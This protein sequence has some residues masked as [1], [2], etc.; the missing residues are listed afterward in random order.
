[1]TRSWRSAIC[2]AVFGALTAC[3]SLVLAQ[4]PQTLHYQGYLTSS[5]GQPV[6]GAAQITFR[7]Y[8]A[9]SGGNLLWQETHASVNVAD[10]N[11]QAILGSTTPFSLPFDAQYWLGITVGADAEM[12][13]R[14]ALASSGY[15]LRSVIADTVPAQSVSGEMIAPGAITLEKLAPVCNL[16]ETLRR[17]ESGWACAPL[18]TPAAEICDGKDNNCDGVVDESWLNA[19]QYD[20]DDA[21][22][23]CG[24]DCTSIYAKPNATG[25]CD[26]AGAPVCVM[27]CGAGYFDL[28]ASVPDGCEFFLE[29]AAIY[30]SSAD[31]AGLDDES[32]GLGPVGTGGGHYPCETI[33]Q[34]L[35]RAATTARTKVLVADGL[36][37][38][39]VTLANGRS[40]LGGYRADTWE[41]HLATTS[42]VIQGVSSTGNH[43]RTVIAAGIAS[44][45]VFEGFVVRGALNNKLSGNSYAIYVS[46]SNA[47][48]EIRNNVIQAGRGGPGAAGGAGLGGSA[49]GSGGNGP[50][51]R[52]ATGTG[53]CDPINDRPGG[54]GGTNSCGVSANGG[55]GGGNQ[56]GPSGSLLEASGIDG[57]SGAGIGAGAGGDAGDDS[58]L[59]SNGVQ[60]VVPPL[61][62]IG[63]GGIAGQ[64]GAHA[65]AA[66][67]CGNAI[68]TVTGGHWVASAPQAGSSGASG[69]GGG[70]GGGGGG[71]HCTSCSELKDRLGGAGGGGGA[72]GCG[73]AGG[74]AGGNA[75]GA[76]GV[77]VA[78][79]GAPVVAGNS[80]ARGDGGAGGVGGTGGAGGQGGAGGA[81]GASV[82]CTGPGGAGGV[83]GAGGHGSGG[84]GGC[85][86]SSFGIYT[87]GVGAPDYCQP[88]AGNTFSAGST[89]AGGQGGVSLINPG[90]AGLA[91]QLADCSFH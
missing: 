5:A 38:E 43:D 67:G 91:G 52:I 45:T 83:G 44:P 50:I 9:A 34:G 17:T 12:A 33:A 2:A 48:L 42:T 63:A 64:A 73:G 11:Y 49:G 61:P 41:R 79:G 26:A 87:S 58:R 51:A 23:G 4:V 7:L 28:N 21:C 15:A 53:F 75:G 78:S 47:S 14:Q 13:P 20:R 76:F 30:V 60:C 3:A 31:P 59:E 62:V 8:D 40:L 36:Y 82:F 24:I 10:G 16:G 68:G 37:G 18:C 74:A 81:G 55:G 29:P 27:N 84:G 57:V 65:G 71:A 69:A 35:V 90:G 22:G 77:F 80:V 66:S 86:G 6:S 88:E 70:G 54:A 19:G 85:G 72:G 32:C 1:V 56:C 46:A 89:G 25:S 39:A